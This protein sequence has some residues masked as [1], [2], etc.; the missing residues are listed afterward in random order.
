MRGIRVAALA[1]VAL[2]LAVST[3]DA[4]VG[5]NRPPAYQHFAACGLGREAKPSHRC[6]AGR[7]GA[8]FRARRRSVHYTVCVRF[9]SR[10]TLC[11][12]G[13]EAER[14]VL[15]VNQVTSSQIGLHRLTWF[16]EGK[17]VGRYFFRIGSGRS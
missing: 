3:A 12:K 2:A 4:R 10:R 5:G 6:P 1:L 8:F 15:Y 13:Q 7:Q 11:A 17:R 16:V 14:G 9:P